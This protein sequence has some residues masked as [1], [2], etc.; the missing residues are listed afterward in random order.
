MLESTFINGLK[1]EIRAELK[2]LEPNGLDKAM[3]LAH[4]IEGKNRELRTTRSGPGLGQFR[5]SSFNLDQRGM[6]IRSPGTPMA[7]SSN[8][9]WN[10]G[11]FCRLTEA[12]IKAKRAKGLCYRCDDKFSPG[13]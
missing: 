9:I 2:I 7:E 8:F 1:A 5:N 6:M 4:K 12:E 11:N 3:E 10:S 13:H